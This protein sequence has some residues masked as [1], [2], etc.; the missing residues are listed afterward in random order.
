MIDE[1]WKRDAESNLGEAR[2]S[3]QRIASDIE[4]Q[5]I[6]LQAGL[7]LLPKR[8]DEV[9]SA[10]QALYYPVSGTNYASLP[11][12]QSLVAS[13]WTTVHSFSLM[14]PANKT[15]SQLF[16]TC[17]PLVR[18]DTSQ[19]YV[20]SQIVINNTTFPI[21]PVFQ[22]GFA[23]AGGTFTSAMISVSIQVFATNPSSITNNSGNARE[24]S[25]R[26]FYMSVWS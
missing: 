4:A 10:S 17:T 16:L 9:D 7:A 11:N 12:L 23:V 1:I 25:L 3:V 18:Y 24:N 19:G 26:T 22:S 14:R 8:I 13:T 15:T 21:A 6:G 20:L 2:T 5:R